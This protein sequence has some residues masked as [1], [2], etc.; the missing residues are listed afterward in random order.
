VFG[1]ERRSRVPNPKNEDALLG[2]DDGG[3]QR[4]ISPG[5]ERGLPGLQIRTLLSLQ[6][7]GVLL[8]ELQVPAGSPVAGKM[9]KDLEIPPGTTVVAIVR[10]GETIITRGDT[11]IAARAWPLSTRTTSSAS[12]SSA[13]RPI[14]RVVAPGR[15]GVR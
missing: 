10:G 9:L 3:D 12:T 14:A 2:V 5:I 1:I 11:K 4:I 13:A 8:S 15:G 6:S 7:G